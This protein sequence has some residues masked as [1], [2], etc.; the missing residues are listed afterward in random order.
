MQLVGNGRTAPKDALSL[1]R[2]VGN[3]QQPRIPPN[4][5]R[6]LFDQHDPFFGWLAPTHDKRIAMLADG[7]WFAIRGQFD[8]TEAQETVTGRLAELPLN[9]AMVSGA[10]R[11]GGMEDGWG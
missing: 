3:L 7:G 4:R 6:L 9:A 11:P 8:K 10:N 1:W 5:R 2:G